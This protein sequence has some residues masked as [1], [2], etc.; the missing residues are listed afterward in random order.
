MVGVIGRR[1]RFESR[2]PVVLLL[3]L[4][5]TAGC[6]SA[7]EPS[8]PT[9]VDGLVVPTP[10][11]DP[12]DFVAEV[13][14]PWLA[15]EDTASYRAGS[16]LSVTREVAPGPQV[17]GVATTAV[18]LGDATDLYAQDTAGNVWW[19]GR[20]GEWQAGTDGAEAGLVVTATPR[21]GDG[22]RT[23]LVPGDGDLLAE[24]VDVDESLDALVG[25]ESASY[26]GVVVIEVTTP[27]AAYRD[28]LVRGVGLVLREDDEGL[29]ELSLDEAS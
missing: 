6:G 16:A 23:A 3:A 9:G 28:H 12:A 15:L 20:E 7:S 13:D 14:S 4:L 24:V 19:F 2:L 5:A 10:A 22:Y 26:D 11:P 1:R 29:A 25:G 18:T 21:L 27:Q 17:V 8:E